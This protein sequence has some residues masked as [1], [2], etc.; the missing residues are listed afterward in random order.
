MSIAGDATRLDVV[1]SEQVARPVGKA[2]GLAGALLAAASLIFSLV[3]T[4]LGLTAVT[5]FIGRFMTK[6]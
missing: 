3:L 4:F 6:R 5:F 2:S 1:A